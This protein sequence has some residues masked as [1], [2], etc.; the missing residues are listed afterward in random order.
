MF[1]TANHSYSAISLGHILRNFKGSIRAAIVDYMIFKIF[2]G[3][4]EYALDTLS[5]ERRTVVY[6]RYH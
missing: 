5:Q 1:I 6:G 4:I 2:V 3:L